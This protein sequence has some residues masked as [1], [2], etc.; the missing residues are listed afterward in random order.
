MGH[1]INSLENDEFKEKLEEAVSNYMGKLRKA[2]EVDSP[3]GVPYKPKIWGAGWNI[4]RF[5]V[6]QYFY[7]KGWPQLSTSD[8]YENA[9]NFILGVHPGINNASFASGIGSNSIKVAYGVNRNSPFHSLFKFC[10][11]QD[12]LQQNQTFD[13]VTARIDIFIHTARSFH[14][15]SILRHNKLVR[16]LQLSKYFF[17]YCYNYPEQ[18]S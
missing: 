18:M 17:D 2:Q 8:F 10:C 14:N 3:Y 12:F 6:E 11:M 9:L 13:P 7:H 5:G 16:Q 1:V 4:Q 15:S